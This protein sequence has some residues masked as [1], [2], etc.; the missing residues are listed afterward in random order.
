MPFGLDLPLA[1]PVLAGVTFLTIWWGHVLVRIVHYYF[2]TRPAPLIFVAGLLLLFG[3]TQVGSDL[4]S[5]GTGI[6]G[7]TLLWDAFEL[8]RQEARVRQGHAP[9]NPRVHHKAAGMLA[10]QLAVERGSDAGE[11]ICLSCGSSETSR[12]LCRRGPYCK[13]RQWDK[14]APAPTLATKD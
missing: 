8:H 9:L 6:V 2:G 4:W 13:V 3:S 5:A 1:G 14:Y 7:L 12:F 11:G 10:S